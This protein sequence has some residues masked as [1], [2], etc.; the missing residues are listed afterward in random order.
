MTWQAMGALLVVPRDRPMPMDGTRPIEA[1]SRSPETSPARRVPT[2][3][4]STPFTACED[5]KTWSFDA[6]VGGY[7]SSVSGRSM[8]VRI[9]V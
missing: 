1:R 4:D 2:M 6:V 5:I 8:K 3:W 7:T 9:E